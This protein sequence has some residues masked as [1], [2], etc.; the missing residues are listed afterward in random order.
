MPWVG[1]APN[2][3]VQRT[4]GTRTG[5][6][7]WQE[8]DAASVPIRSDDHDT[9]DQDLANMIG[10]CLKRDG[11]NQAT[12]NIH[13]GGHRIVNVGAATSL[14]DAATL[15]QV[16]GG[17][18]S[19]GGTAG[20]TG[21]ALTLTLT[22]APTAYAAGMS[23]RFLPAAVNTTA[24]TININGLGVKNIYRGTAPI[25]AF[26]LKAGHIYTL[27]Y[28]GTQFQLF[29]PPNMTGI[30]GD[31]ALDVAPAGAVLCS[32][33]TIGNASSGAT[34][35]ANADT[36]ALFYLL[37]TYYDNTILPLQDSSGNPVSRGSS[38]AAD[39][40]ANRRL[41]LPDL[42]G[43][44]TVG[45][46]NMG[47]S[48]ANR[49]TTAGSGIDGTTLGASGG[50]QSVTLTVAQ[51]PSHNHGGTTGNAG[52]HNHTVPNSW[53]PHA[54]NNNFTGGTA[55]GHQF[56][57]LT[58]STAPDHAH[59]IPAEGGG[60]AHSNMPPSWIANKFIWL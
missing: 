45:R 34:E 29:G 51:I 3:T 59:A 37:W 18:A 11:G 19:W 16:Q 10:E 1:T 50:A 23:V 2:Q 53:H 35:R 24:A 42:R 20:G 48:A 8:A 54:Q 17:A 27:I 55:Y 60:Q 40:A 47:G 41:P 14:T 31:T 28:D 30:M 56:L 32:G 43:R 9:H 49:V 57:T 21:N 4:D 26:D 39:F 13:L 22:P 44:M 15:G 7:T 36:E 25:G 33:R 38:A 52:A 46:D 6:Q 58:T 12:G 5:S